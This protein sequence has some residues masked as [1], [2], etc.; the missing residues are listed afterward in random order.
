MGGEGRRIEWEG[1]AGG[2]GGKG[3]QEGRV[4]KRKREHRRKERRI[5]ENRSGGHYC[6]FDFT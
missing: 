3:G 2:E 5:I 1:R 4:G 6:L